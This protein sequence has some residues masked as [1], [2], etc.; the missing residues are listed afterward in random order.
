M[1][2]YIRAHGPRALALARLDEGDS[3][4]VIG[5]VE[6]ETTTSPSNE[7]GTLS[8]PEKPCPAR[9]AAVRRSYRDT[10]VVDSIGGAL[11]H[12]FTTVT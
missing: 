9:G 1:T 8:S 7:R 6:T 2:Y 11:V 3:I 5:H 10:V 4:V 12:G